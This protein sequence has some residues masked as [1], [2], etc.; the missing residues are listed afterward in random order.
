MGKRGE[1]KGS[2]SGIGRD[3]KEGQRARRI[4][5]NQWLGGW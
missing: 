1:R 3:R 5:V 2:G 4:H